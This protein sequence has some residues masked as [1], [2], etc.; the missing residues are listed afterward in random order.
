MKIFKQI[1]IALPVVIDALKGGQ[2]IVYPTE[3]CY[4]LGC[5]A[6]NNGAV[7]N[8]FAIKGR[9]AAKTV[10]MLA[11]DVE[12]VKEF[13]L[14]DDFVGSIAKKYWP[15]SISDSTPRPGLTLILPVKDRRGL[16]PGVIASDNT[17]AFRVTSYPFARSIVQTLGKPLV[18][19][20][21]NVSGGANPYSI[22]SVVTSFANQSVKPDLV[23]DAGTL[24]ERPPTTIA[25]IENGTIKIVRQGELQLI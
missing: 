20:S 6:T 8:I 24:P 3:T 17:V 1:D 16:A 13:V 11:A 22:D 2:T 23:I 9:D 14:W 19:T 15:L 4:G 18:S 10:L 12:M 5:D 25:R 21:A 7:E